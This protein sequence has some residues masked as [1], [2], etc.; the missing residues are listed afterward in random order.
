M[1]TEIETAVVGYS[2][3]GAEADI[4]LMVIHMQTSVLMKADNFVAV[5]RNRSN[6]LAVAIVDAVAVVVV[7]AA[8]YTAHYG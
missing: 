4:A 6:I 3:R 5:Q 2:C 8:S 7:A 1:V